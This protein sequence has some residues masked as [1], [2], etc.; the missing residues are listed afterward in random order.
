M[1]GWSLAHRI[2]PLLRIMEEFS[3]RARWFSIRPVASQG[4]WKKTHRLAPDGPVRGGYIRRVL[5]FLPACDIRPRALR[6]A[7]E[8]LFRKGRKPFAVLNGLHN[9]A[10]SRLAPGSFPNYC[11]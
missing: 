11:G 2:D 6:L 4:S 5:R 8:P 1:A 9:E 10:N 3:H 7:P